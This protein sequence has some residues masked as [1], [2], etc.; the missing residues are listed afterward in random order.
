MQREWSCT[1]SSANTMQHGGT[2]CQKLNRTPQFSASD[3][4]I[5]TY[6]TSQKTMYYAKL[7]VWSL[8]FVR[9]W[10]LKRE[11]RGFKDEGEQIC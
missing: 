4:Q 1:H 8:V 5:E 6:A 7:H 10:A 9:E 3:I 11:Q 2:R